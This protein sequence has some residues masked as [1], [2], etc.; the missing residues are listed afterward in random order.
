MYSYKLLPKKHIRLA[1]IHLGEF[2]DDIAI[3]LEP[4]KLSAGALPQYEA[5]SY[6]WGSNDNFSTIL[7]K[8]GG[9]SSESLLV[10]LNLI[11]ALRYMRLVDRPRVM[12]VDAICIDQA[13]D[14]EKGPQV[15]MMGEIY[16]L[17]ERVVVWLGPEENGSERAMKLM[18]EIGSQ[19]EV[20][21]GLFSMTPAEGASDTSWTDRKLPLALDEED[22]C[23]ICHLFCRPWFERLWVRQEIFLANSAAVVAC[24]SSLV[25]WPVFRRAWAC[26]YIKDKK[27]FKLYSQLFDRLNMLQGFLFHQPGGVRLTELRWNIGQTLCRD[28]RDRIYSV[29]SLLEQRFKDFHII[30]DY[31]KNVAQV[32]GDVVKKYL[33]SS[34]D[35]NIISQCQGKSD[36]NMPTWIPDWSVMVE[37]E[38]N[39]ANTCAS[40][41]FG[42]RFEICKDRLRV[43]GV[44]IGTIRILQNLGL[45]RRPDL[46]DFIIAIRQMVSGK[47]LLANYVGGGNIIEAYVRT[48]CLDEVAENHE[49]PMQGTPR[50]KMTAQ[51]LL[52]IASETIP[53]PK[54][55]SALRE[56]LGYA[57][58]SLENRYI[59][60]TANG[61][62]GVAPLEAMQGD[63]VCVALG[64]D[65]PLLLR[66][67]G[68]DVYTLV[69]VCYACGVTK[70]E[71]VLGSLP[72]GFRHVLAWDETT[73]NFYHGFVSEAGR[74]VSRHDPRLRA[75][76]ADPQNDYGDTKETVDPEILRDYGVDIKH[77]ELA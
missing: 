17:A 43:A 47:N 41:P 57:G 76:S 18:Q 53:V 54:E 60:E 52:Q 61:Y 23:S 50:L 24:G 2:K 5:L 8:D 34:R 22:L 46:E 25:S 20:D 26:L 4:I 66:P 16:R 35:L 37:R 63:E 55:K 31:T 56:I 13:N 62:I 33:Q 70:G 29:L 44:S 27:D 77:F 3:S 12:W 9:I 67:I 72:E 74:E 69:G 49:P 6:V 42:G 51:L 10:T 40:G 21:F 32:Y 11:V 28:P 58:D 36:L 39:M 73:N 30:P 45:C 19:V 7:V 75:L 65:A 59:F 48:L 1:T 68:N 71:A 15:A 14:I 38:F 64:C